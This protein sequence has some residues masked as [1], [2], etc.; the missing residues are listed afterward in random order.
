MAYKNELDYDL[1]DVCQVCGEDFG[2]HAFSNNACPI[3]DDIQPSRKTGYYED[4]FFS[5]WVEED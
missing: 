5:L 1:T 2:T 4:K 3:L